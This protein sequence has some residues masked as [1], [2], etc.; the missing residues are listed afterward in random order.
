MQSAPEPDGAEPVLF[1]ETVVAEIADQ[2]VGRQVDVIEGDDSGDRLLHHL[3][4]PSRF[5]AR[6]ESLPALQT[7]LLPDCDQ[8]LEVFPR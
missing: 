1:L 4:A 6:I 8:E 3:S 7:E 2:F 5:T